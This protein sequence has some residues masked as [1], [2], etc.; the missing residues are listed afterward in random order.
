MSGSA[1]LSVVTSVR[2][3]ASNGETSSA[4]EISAPSTAI[5]AS[6]SIT[7]MPILRV[8]K[9]RTAPSSTATGRRRRRARTSRRAATSVPGRLPGRLGEHQVGGGLVGRQHS[10]SPAGR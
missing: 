6:T 3:S 4:R 8:A 7:A 9:P 2:Y 5:S 1:P 10:T